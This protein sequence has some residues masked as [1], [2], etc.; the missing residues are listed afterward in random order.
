MISRFRISH[1]FAAAIAFAAAC[2]ISA[3][4]RAQESAK[5]HPAE[6]PHAISKT[7][8][9]LF[10]ADDALHVHNVSN[11]V[12]RPMKT[13]IA[14]TATE[15]AFD[16]EG[17]ANSEMKTRT[18]L[19]VRVRGWSIGSGI[20]SQPPASIARYPPSVYTRQTKR[21]QPRVVP[22]RDANRVSS[23]HRR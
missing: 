23:R 2:V 19:W 17:D 13:N 9:K 6:K 16:T 8:K 1:Y 15:L 21:I 12:F 14:F 4:V 7:G 18:Q 22:R 20:S 10:G 11:V 3:P 5:S